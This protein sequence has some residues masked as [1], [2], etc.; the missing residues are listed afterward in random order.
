[1]EKLDEGAFHRSTCSRWSLSPVDPPWSQTRPHRSHF[2]ACSQG[3]FEGVRT[4]P[5]CSQAKF[6]FLQ[7]SSST[8]YN[9]STVQWYCYRRHTSHH[10]VATRSS[11]I[12]IACRSVC[13]WNQEFWSVKIVLDHLITPFRG[14][15]SL[16]YTTKAL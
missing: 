1:M 14:S 5:P 10:A 16:D 8:E 2:L 9:H 4:N 6:I 15:W 3:G 12:H 7:D 13:D 11:H